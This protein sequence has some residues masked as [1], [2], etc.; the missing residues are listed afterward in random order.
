M[1]K[2]TKKGGSSVT[3]M[4]EA[5]K[6]ESAKKKGTGNTAL[7]RANAVEKKG[8]AA[9]V[10]KAGSKVVKAV[11][12]ALT[13]KVVKKGAKAVV[14]AIEGAV[15]AV[16]APAKKTQFFGRP[17][18]TKKDVDPV[19]VKAERNAQH[20]AMMQLDWYRDYRVDSI[21]LWVE[22]RKAE[23]DG[24]DV[25]IERINAKLDKISAKRDKARAA[26]KAEGSKV[27]TAVPAK[28]E[29]VNEDGPAELEALLQI[30]A[31]E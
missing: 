22:R 5:A 16:T 1:S 17:K 3:K 25:A 29:K 6:A 18:V 8:K 13:K 14:K 24:D 12:K 15:D 26:W 2:G 7:D 21:A 30:P 11:E 4:I 9:P 19:K 20:A 27:P 31:A 23:A 10:K 28:A